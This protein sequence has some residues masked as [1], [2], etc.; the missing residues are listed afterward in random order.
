MRGPGLTYWRR[1]ALSV[2]VT[3]LTVP[4][5]AQA[6]TWQVTNNADPGSGGCSPSDCSLR[7]AITAADGD[8]G[9]DVVQVPAGV[10][11]LAAGALPITNG[12][13]IVGTAGAGATAI[14][15]HEAS[16]IFSISSAA[17]S[18]AIS[19]LTLE[20][21]RLAGGGSAIRSAAPQPLT[22]SGDVFFQNT[23]GGA[24]T[25]GNGAVS[26]LASGSAALTVTNSTFTDN[27]AG[28]AGTS[29]TSSGQGS[30]G[31]IDFSPTSGTLSVS[32]SS[33]LR[34]TA[35]GNGGKG[36]SSAQGEGGAIAAFGD[37]NA[38][39]ANSSFSANRAGGNGGEGTSSAEGDGGAVEFF[40]ES[41]ADSL[42]VSGSTFESNEAGG[43]AGAG[44]GSGA[45]DGGGVEAGGEGSA[46]VL[47]DTFR[48]SNANHGEGGG[49]ASAVPATLVNDTLSGNAATGGMGGN[50]AVF[51]ATTSLKNTIIVGGA[52]I[53]GSNCF[54]LAGS[55]TSAGHNLEDTAPSQCGLGASG[56][57]VGV[58]PLLG[59][60]Q[61]NGG[62]TE[63]QALLPGSPAIDAG[64]DIGCP[65]TDQRGVL[66]P[67]G[68]ACDI[69]AFEI[70]TPAAIT[71]QA[72]AIAS[73][74][75]TLNGTFTNPDIA[76]GGVFYQYG[77]TIGYGSQTP[78]Q[79]IGA[80]T[81]QAPF[82]ATVASLAPGTTYHFR[83]VVANAVATVLGGDETFK[84]G[85]KSATTPTGAGVA[86]V[87]AALA[88]HP[89]R[90]VRIST[91]APA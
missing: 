60:L 91:R 2:V 9:V 47:N 55:L 52:A 78:A 37:V 46:T 67:A 35:G 25:S 57:K 40:G 81:S 12:M 71:G 49:F 50:L 83:A 76:S 34:N 31:G 62:P 59:E 51:G 87:L 26:V 16:Q 23:T 72:T 43:S 74:S 7:A 8:V 65:A 39:I 6:T 42:S 56:D 36:V 82:S 86:P 85:T 19:G 38:T 15:A 27:A 5:V 75:A 29:A 45:G 1:C 54:V 3:L 79:P 66:R 73:S 64:D 70:A 84:S 20:H 10:Y 13:Q 18:V 58:N 90:C 48:E 24:G 88:V 30:G 53:S 21:G 41:P 44:S 28:G 69:G 32:G 77:P 14:N 80:D 11:T 61:S 22:L 17:G 68:A 89:S 63:T 4:A 33:F